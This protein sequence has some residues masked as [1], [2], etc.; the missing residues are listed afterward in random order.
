ML[1]VVT[2]EQTLK[3]LQYTA[4]QKPA[5]DAGRHLTW[6]LPDDLA[7]GDAKFI[8]LY[9]AECDL[10]DQLV[11]KLACDL[12]FEHLEE[13]QKAVLRFIADASLRRAANHVPAFVEQY[14]RVV[15]E[16]T[17]VFTTFHLE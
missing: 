6:K 10:M 4:R 11:A 5:P 9:G 13:P 8:V 2:V 3:K 7:T 15:E 12:R 1:S 17:I 14:A 16:H